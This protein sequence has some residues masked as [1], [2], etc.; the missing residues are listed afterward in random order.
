MNIVTGG[1]GLV[2]CHLLYELVSKGK[3]VKAIRRNSS[4]IFQVK[5][6]FSYYSENAEELFQKIEWIEADI[7]DQMSL[8]D[9]FEEGDKVYN[10][11][12]FVSFNPSDKEKIIETNIGGTTNVVNACLN[13]KVNKLCHISSVAALG[14]SVDG[15]PIDETRIWSPSK[16]KGSYYKL[17]KFHSE[18]EV[19]RA[20]EDG[21]NAVIVNPSI[22]IGPGNWEK[23]SS[24]FFS[25]I[26][27]GLKYYTSGSMGF[28]D[29]RDVARMMVLLMESEICAERFLL[30]SENVGY[31][32]L[33]DL[34][35]DALNKEKPRTE[36]KPWLGAIG[37]R[38]EKIR[39]FI[40]AS[41]PQITR[42]TVSTSF[43]AVKF[44]NKKIR[45]KLGVEFVPFEQ[46]I[47]DTAT[48]FLKDK[49]SKK[50]I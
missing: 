30:N 4:D 22:I 47:N 42:D 5:H 26:D 6:V 1:T 18:M 40:T 28:V 29:V 36:V 27:K 16:K 49:S 19:W 35:A 14:N 45:E 34:V 41:E 38:L 24:Q 37:W 7:L 13:K 25:V 48:L 50:L 15:L 33:L 2:G 9:V 46:S 3:A 31:K 10:C 44:S 11:A 43:K 20:I 23:G 21:L 12:S 8:E 17:S 39:S 32:K